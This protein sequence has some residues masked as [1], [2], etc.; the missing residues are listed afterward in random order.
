MARR[1][2]RLGALVLDDEPLPVADDPR[3]IAALLVGIREL[4]LDALPWTREMR[5]WQARVMFLRRLGPEANWPDVSDAALLASLEEW[6]APWLAGMSRREHLARLNLQAALA[7][8]LSW[9]GRQELEQQAPTHL[10]VPSGSRLKLDYLAGEEPALAVRL[11]EMF[12]ARETPRVAAG[13]VQ[14][15]LQLLS[16]A[17]RP[18]QVTR[19]LASFWANTYPE[20]RKDL[21][22]RYAKHFWPEDPLSA[23][24]T[25]RARPRR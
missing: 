16:P 12:G 6:L 20:V 13:R 19:D 2:T 18:V 21:R 3:I 7:G 14:V 17:G 11:Q 10:T 22:A 1:Q 15:T 4:G 25:S 5:T 8:L 24:P 23:S 9:A